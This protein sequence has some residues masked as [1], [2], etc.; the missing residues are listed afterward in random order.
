MVWISS[1]LLLLTEMAQARVFIRDPGCYLAFGKIAGTRNGEVTLLIDIG[2]RSAAALKIKSDQQ[3]ASLPNGKY[4]SLKV[5]TQKPGRAEEL[6][7][8]GF[9]SSLKVAVKTHGAGNRALTWSGEISQG[10]CD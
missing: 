1:L 8:L 10:K 2:T 9:M 5:L 6:A 4:V 3:T 7:L